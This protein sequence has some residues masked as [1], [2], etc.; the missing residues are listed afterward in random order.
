MIVPGS[1][2]SAFNISLESTEDANRTIVHNIGRAII[3]KISIKIEGNE[4][5]SLDDADVYNTFK[6]LWLIKRQLKNL[7]YQGI[8][9]DNITLRIGAGDGIPA[10][11]GGKDKAITNA[12]GNRFY[13]PLD[14][15]TFNGPS[16]VLSSWAGRSVIESTDENAKFIINGISLEYEVITNASLARMIKNQYSGKMAVLYDRV[17]RHRVI[18]LNKSDTMWKIN[19]NTPAKSMKGILF[20]FKKSDAISDSK[21]YKLINLDYYRRSSQSTLRARDV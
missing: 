18:A 2:R 19:L 16:T 5:Y 11:N 13:V 14:F 7:A 9:S 12:F 6:D 15:G 1:A 20:L 10:A 17:L 3:K 21:F 4:V 8:E